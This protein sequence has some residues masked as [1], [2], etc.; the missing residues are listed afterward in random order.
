[1]TETQ[2]ANIGISLNILK[3]FVRASTVYII[4]IIINYSLD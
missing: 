3:S 1:M 4:R 2:L